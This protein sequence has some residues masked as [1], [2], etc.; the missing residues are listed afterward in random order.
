MI[1]TVSI[2]S[3]AKVGS[4]LPLPNLLDPAF[5]KIDH[6]DNHVPYFPIDMPQDVE[7]FVTNNA[8]MTLAQVSA[9]LSR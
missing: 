2:H 8:K 9:A 3:N 1:G 6:H 7:D 5:V 4:I